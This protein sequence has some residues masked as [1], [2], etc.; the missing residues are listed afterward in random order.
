[1]I[2][3]CPNCSAEVDLGE[4]SDDL[5]DLKYKLTCPE[6]QEHLRLSAGQNA[7][8]ECPYMGPAKH[9]AILTA[10]YDKRRAQRRE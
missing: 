1:M 4:A 9:A 7:N 2:V 5:T 6:L 10:R 3:K 8:L